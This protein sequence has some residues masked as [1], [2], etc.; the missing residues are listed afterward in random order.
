[1]KA[2]RL[3]LFRLYDENK[4]KGRA[5]SKAKYQRKLFKI[6]VEFYLN[7]DG[8]LVEFIKERLEEGETKSGLI[9]RLIREE[10]ERSKENGEKK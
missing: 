2:D 8:E 4:L 3:E 9:K 6:Y 10:I 1:M 7:T 5:G